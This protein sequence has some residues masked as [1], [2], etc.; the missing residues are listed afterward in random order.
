MIDIEQIRN[1]IDGNSE[2]ARFSAWMALYSSE[3]KKAH[4][5]LENILSSENP[6]TKILFVKFLANIEE[7]KSIAY[8][9]R[10]VKDINDYVIEN[11]INAFNKNKLANKNNF[12]ID[13]LK[14]PSQK[15][16]IFAVDKLSMSVTQQALDHIIE[17][18]PEADTELLTNI[19]IGL[20]FYTDR[21]IAPPIYDFL[22]DERESIRFG[23]VMVLGSLYE[24]GFAEFRKWLL[25]KINDESELIRHGVIW[26]L[27]NVYNKRNL[28]YLLKFSVDDPSP[29]V[30]QE[31]I[32]SLADFP[33]YK[34]IY[35]IF[36]IL[37]NEKDSMVLLKGEA[38]LLSMPN[39]LLV[40]SMKK[41]LHSR[42]KKYKD[43]A[44][45]LY[46]EHQKHSEKY[47]IFLKK[48]LLKTKKPKDQLPIV[49]S[50]GLLEN[51]KAV[52]FLEE[53]IFS[54]PLLT[55]T[56]MAAITKIW[57]LSEEFPALR[58]LTHPK[59]S[60]LFKQIPL[61]HL[62]KIKSDKIYTEKLVDHL[63]MSLD[64]KN[65]NIRYLSA[66]ALI[67]VR[68]ERILEP[69]FRTIIAETDETAR[70]LLK[71][72]IIILFN[73]N[74][75]LFVHVF[76]QNKDNSEAIQLLFSLFKDS[77]LKKQQ[78]MV[79]TSA[80]LEKPSNILDTD[81]KDLL[82]DTLFTFIKREIIKVEDIINELKNPKLVNKLLHLLIN[83]FDTFS[84][85][86]I[87]LPIQHILS[88]IK[89]N[90]EYNASVLVDLFGFSSSTK[91]IPPLIHIITHNE[92]SDLQKK[93]SNSLK[94][95][96]EVAV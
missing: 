82:V 10:L 85:F 94:K 90:P 41:L 80:L 24:S 89:N 13:A 32:L 21:K 4:E 28:K 52:D 56:G 48:Q 81:Y 60:E 23:A 73:Q 64:S 20:R 14:A 91:A 5:E 6:I 84:K 83:K 44:M 9:I 29:L 30:R 11:A 50:I 55:Y 27:S 18:I 72:N 49:E 65:L 68:N 7:E 78:I 19:L 70:K 74:P 59:L 46:A 87:D 86:S 2:D 16:K 92:I 96:I 75:Y 76:E 95:V 71:E 35:H 88:L 26:S 45:L 61:K 12:L 63:I 43:K 3:E 22:D 39:P 15:A 38:V 58:Y 54:N 8:I 36:G 53:H 17:L 47:F 37:I 33:T 42:K 40:K 69:F 67:N 93:A 1:D 57:G 62:T 51:R 77:F 79:L 34:I 66:Q 31:A 25:K